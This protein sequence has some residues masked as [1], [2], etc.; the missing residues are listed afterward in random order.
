MLCLCCA[1]GVFVLCLASSSVV[2]PCLALLLSR[3]D[4]KGSFLC[5]LF[6][7]LKNTRILDFL[8]HHLGDVVDH[9]Q[10]NSMTLGRSTLSYFETC[11]TNTN[12]ESEKCVRISRLFFSV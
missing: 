6:L 2:L 4:L 8:V 10:A 11:C 5:G 7:F 1:C 3:L 12:D 9:A